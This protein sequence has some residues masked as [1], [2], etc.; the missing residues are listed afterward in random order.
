[1]KFAGTIVMVLALAA[2]STPK[3]V[4]YF[5]DRTDG[6]S[7]QILNQQVIKVQPSD[8]LSIV[9]NSKNPELAN[10]FNL[11]VYTSRI[12]AIERT[13][14]LTASQQISCYT[15]DTEGNIDFPQLGKLR[16]AGMQR[17]EIARL[18]KGKLVET[19]LVNDP[20]VT[21]EFA[22]L[23]FSVLGEVAHPGRFTIDQD[24]ISIL[25]AI[26]MA[27]DLTINGKRQNVTV[28][29]EN[30]GKQDIYTLDLTSAYNL[31]SSPVYYLQQ[32]D[33][34]YVEPNDTRI[35]QSTVNGNNVRS[36][37]FWISVTS[38]LTSIAVLVVNLTK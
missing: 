21:V 28:L 26:S 17:E 36:T 16:V 7:I 5:Q 20:V 25:D 29:R 31:Y 30:N 14:N 37:S 10:M 11:P 9:V 34:V 6:A 24:K 27:G 23:Y 12:G 2:C 38:L 13:S 35:R 22:N 18:I 3:D 32:K 1:M 8:K 19:Q 15:V 4:A 33:I